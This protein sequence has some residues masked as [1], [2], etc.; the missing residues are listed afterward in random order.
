[1]SFKS[2]RQV[3]GFLESQDSWKGR[4]RF[5]Q[6]LGC[7]AEIVGPAVAAQ[8]RPVSMQR[9]VLQVATSSAA[10]AQNLAFERHRIL[11]K[12]NTR[13]PLELTDIRFS[14]VHWR[15]D[16]SQNPYTSSAESA[17]WQHPSQ[18]ADVPIPKSTPAAETH[19][20]H[21]AFRNWARVVRLRSQSLPLCPTCQC[22]TPAGELQRWSVCA[23]C[24]AKKMG[25]DGG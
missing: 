5:Q 7:W 13:L 4:R 12:L 1:M 10:W 24:A 8:T 9:H 6:L 16:Y 20:P 15:S 2:L 3:L 22:P 14:T 23:L 17:L 18:V 25:Q 19:D 11:E 21:T